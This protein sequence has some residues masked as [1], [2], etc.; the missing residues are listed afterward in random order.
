M[1]CFV[2]FFLYCLF[3]FCF[4]LC[5][6]FCFFNFVISFFVRYCS[7]SCTNCVYVSGLS[8]SHCVSF[9][10]PDLSHS[11][12]LQCL[13][14]E[15]HE[16]W[17]T[18]SRN[19]L[20]FRST[21]D[22]YLLLICLSAVRVVVIVKL[23]V[24]TCFVPSCNVHYDFPIKR[25]PFFLTSVWFY[26]L[27]TLYESLHIYWRPARFSYQM[28]FVSLKSSTMGITCWAGTVIHFWVPE[29]T[30]DLSWG[31]RFSI[32][33]FL[34]NVLKTVVS[35]FILFSVLQAMASDYS[36]GNIKLY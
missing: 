22:R 17:H 23:H 14:Q 31:S 9:H 30:L 15:K 34:F 1:S 29:F 33:S 4:W 36:F 19:C 20:H 25:F 3:L 6:C 13:L 11:S 18:W 7:V 21:W 26:V 2:L 5:F 35:H 8:I 27:L 12:L 32:F 24:L 16:D 10:N 28:W